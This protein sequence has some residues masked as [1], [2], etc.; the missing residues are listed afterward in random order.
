MKIA[1]MGNRVRIGVL[2]ALSMAGP[3]CGR[4]EPRHSCDGAVDLNPHGQQ[5]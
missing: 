2:L 3:A 1:K 4:G 5:P